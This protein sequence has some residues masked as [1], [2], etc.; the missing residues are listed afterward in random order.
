MLKS[1]ESSIN[2]HEKFANDDKIKVYIK[3]DKN[4]ET[5]KEKEKI[6]PKREVENPQLGDLIE[7][8]IEILLDN[9]HYLYGINF[10]KDDK[11]LT[12][13]IKKC[14][15]IDKENQKF[16]KPHFS[17]KNKSNQIAHQVVA[18]NSSEVINSL[19]FGASLN[20]NLNFLANIVFSCGTEKNKTKKENKKKDYSVKT[21]EVEKGIIHLSEIRS[22][23]NTDMKSFFV[24]QEM[25]KEKVKEFYDTY[26]TYVPTQIKIGGRFLKQNSIKEETVSEDQTRKYN[27]DV[28][29]PAIVVN[30]HFNKDNTRKNTEKN[31]E[32]ESYIVTLGGD[33]GLSQTEDEWVKSI[34]KDFRTWEIISV[35]NY[36]FTYDLLEESFRNQVWELTH[37]NK[38]YSIEGNLYEGYYNDD[39]KKHGKGTLIWDNGDMYEGLWKNDERCGEGKIVFQNGDVYEGTWENDTAN[40]KGVFRFSNGDFYEGEWR[41][42]YKHGYGKWTSKNGDVF[43]GNW[44]MDKRNG[45]GKK[46]FA[47][48]DVF[49][50]YWKDGQKLGTGMLT[51]INK[52]VYEGELKDYKKNGKGK[53]LFANGDQYDGDWMNDK[54]NGKGTFTWKNGGQYKGEWKDDRKNGKGEFFFETNYYSGDWKDDKKNGKGKFTFG[55]YTYD[56]DWMND[57]KTGKGKLYLKDQMIYSGKW[58]DNKND[59]GD[60]YEENWGNKENIQEHDISVNSQICKGDYEE[61]DKRKDPAK[62]L[63]SK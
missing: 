32:K 18:E 43:E 40:G 53:M 17:G 11:K 21:I 25:T 36:I 42:S 38:C 45:K 30:P 37:Y 62:I 31:E 16:F 49:E 63:I 13:G 56:G 29:I 34:N 22:V 35:E 27:L 10:A 1:Q 50:G 26:G 19:N 54:K 2:I 52:D 58:K 57:K 7:E 24:N 48:G 33:I 15:S 8:Q 20:A 12:P 6:E 51:Y 41:F 60:S 47:N 59:K 28:K 55:D 3:G 44:R 23:V 46:V 9:C 14:F 39:G 61:E 4:N 5:K